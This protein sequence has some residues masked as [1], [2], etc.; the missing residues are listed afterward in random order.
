MIEKPALSFPVIVMHVP[1][2]GFVTTLKADKR[3]LQTLAEN[4]GLE[5]ASKFEAEL[6]ISQWKKNG[7]RIRGT[8]IA[9]YVQQCIVSLE[10]IPAHMNEKIDTILVPE[11]SR[12]AKVQ[13]NDSGEIVLN[14]DG[15]DIPEV[16]E[17]DSVDIGEIAEEFFELALDPYPRKAGLDDSLVNV[18]YGGE[19]DESEKPVSPFAKLADL[20]RKN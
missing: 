10:P 5:E 7:I 2:K 3:E 12:L 16:F 4:H 17:G 15:P 6:H 1:A 8:I 13:Y 9:D 19:T 20:K 14:A 18:T 11:N